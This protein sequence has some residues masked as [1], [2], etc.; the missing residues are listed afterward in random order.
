MCEGVITAYKK[1]KAS[2][3]ESS[4]RGKEGVKVLIHIG[5]SEKDSLRRQHLRI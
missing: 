3:K 2:R 1:L 4:K 5:R